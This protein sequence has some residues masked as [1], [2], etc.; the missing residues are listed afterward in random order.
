MTLQDVSTLSSEEL[1]AQLDDTIAQIKQAE[2]DPAVILY[3]SLRADGEMLTNAL[4]QYA[5]ENGA[6]QTKYVQFQRI[7]KNI[8]D[9]K[10]VCES[11]YRKK[12]LKDEDIMP[13]KS[14]R[15]EA[16]AVKI[17]EGTGDINVQS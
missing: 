7:T 14:E 12:K 9:W 4:R 15:V 8:I 16:R 5:L 13:F 17:K 10:G 6:F 2:L 1:I 3:Q 11:L